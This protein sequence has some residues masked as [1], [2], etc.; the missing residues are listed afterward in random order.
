LNS[1][2]LHKCTI[3]K[4]GIRKNNK[5]PYLV[6]GFT[7]FSKVRYNNQDCFVF[8]R[9]ASGNFDIRKLDGIVVSRG[10]HVRYLRLLQHGKTLLT[11]R[12]NMVPLYI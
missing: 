5:A 8:G 7:L 6:R 11:E 4:G 9:R 12:K 2:N 10:K 3:A 1:L